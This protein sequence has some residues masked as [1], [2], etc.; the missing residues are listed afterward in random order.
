[1]PSKVWSDNGTNIVGAITELSRSLRQ[2]DRSKIVSTARRKDVEWSFNPPHA[3]HQGGLWERM[4]RT[5]RQILVALLTPNARLSDDVLNTIM[6]EIE[7]LINSRPLT[8]CS[9]D[10]DDD[11]PLTPNHILL[12]RGNYSYPWWCTTQ[13]ADTY[14]RRWKHV[15]HVVEQFWRRWIREYLP[16]LN[17]RQIWLNPLPNVK[18]G[19]LVL[20]SD[21]MC[22]L[23]LGFIQI[24]KHVVLSRL[25]WESSMSIAETAWMIFYLYAEMVSMARGHISKWYPVRNGTWSTFGGLLRKATR[26]L[27]SVRHGAWSSTL[28]TGREYRMMLVKGSVTDMILSFGKSPH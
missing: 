21:V 13:V 18:P 28:E 25:I 1:M 4:I 10:V 3:S 12:L 9:E 2:L 16:E 7:N 11:A 23:V 5:I 19:D 14:R 15:Q 17:R 20:I 22:A 8:K 26:L 24:G 6:C 27:L